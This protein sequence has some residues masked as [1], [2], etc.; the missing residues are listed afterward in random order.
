MFFY[1]AKIFDFF[2]APSHLAIFLAALGVLLY[3]ARCKKWGSRLAALGVALLL[4]MMFGPVSH[5]LAVPLETRFPAPPRNMEAPDGIIVLGGTVDENLSDQL[6]R[7]V[8]NSAAER[9]TAPIELVRRFPNARLVFTGG[10]ASGFEAPSREA[11]T[12]RRFW[13]EMG[14]DSDRVVYEDRSRNT[15]ENALFTRDLVNP[16]PGERWLLVTS[17]IHMPRA[18][19]IFRKLGFSVVPYPVDFRT[20]G[21]LSHLSAPRKAP[22]SLELV[23]AAAHEWIGLLAYWL[24]GK[25]D[26]LFP[27]P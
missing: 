6:D 17:A 18:V 9:V 21:V 5:L 2:A 14:I 25:T 7:V 10:S 24:T 1:A 8:I 27:A 4:A 19:G 16:K 13:R 20:N 22:Q 23:D 11:T 12:V 15:Y 3:F 26:A